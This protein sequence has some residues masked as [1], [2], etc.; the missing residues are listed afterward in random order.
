MAKDFGIGLNF[1][2]KLLN[3][4][5]NQWLYR[6]ALRQRTPFENLSFP[7]VF[8]PKSF[9][10]ILPAELDQSHLVFPLLTALK[11]KCPHLSLTLLGKKNILQVFQKFFPQCI[12]LE[13]ES[14]YL[15]VPNYQ[16]LLKR[17]GGMGIE[18]C[19]N[20]REPLPLRILY[21]VAKC[22]AKFKISSINTLFFNLT[23]TQ[24]NSLDFQQDL[25]K[26]LYGETLDF[27]ALA[28][29]EQKRIQQK[30]E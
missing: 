15:D 24:K 23:F 10:I 16:D 13:D 9:L 29:L 17:I 11:K 14:M 6:R 25:F 22:P 18:V 4:L 7:N 1:P 3:W 5:P 27:E 20:F 8:Q 19:I 21:L 2:L 26:Y 12:V 30:S 28:Q